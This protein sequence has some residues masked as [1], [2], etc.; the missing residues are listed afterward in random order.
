MHVLLMKIRICYSAIMEAEKSEKETQKPY[1]V[2][3]FYKYVDVH[4]PEALAA[5]VQKLASVLH[6]TGRVIVAH[7]GINGT[8]EGIVE[9]TEKFAE[10]FLAD[11][12]FSDV[13]IKR[14]AGTGS[15]F[16]KLSVKVRK[17][18]VGTG[19]SDEEANPRVATAPRITPEELR[20]WYEEQRDFVVVD[21]R[22]NYEFASG[23][24]KNSVEPCI[25]ASRHLPLMID[26]LAAVKDKTIV[27]VCT[28]GVRCE[29]MAAYLQNKGFENVRQL[30][31]GIHSYMQKYPGKDFLGT[32]YTFDQR[33]TMDFGGEREVIGKCRLCGATS[34]RYADCAEKTCHLHFIACDACRDE[35]GE[36][37]CSDECKRVLV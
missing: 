32:L 29:K 30:D 11:S 5:Q 24:F 23:H 35:K 10:E 8:L 19:F 31:G 14:S 37:Y 21:M 7:E 26:R 36:V 12:R 6:L 17:E 2:L 22:N 20:E 13:Q 9:N 16:P 25:S 27:T 15:S 4:A 1:Q 28:G 34:E 18:I 33:V 3:L